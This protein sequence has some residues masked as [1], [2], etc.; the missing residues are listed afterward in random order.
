MP[1]QNEPPSS[2]SS[3]FLEKLRRF[4]QGHERLKHRVHNGMRVPLP[5]WGRV[6]MGTIYF[7]VPV[8]T[9]WYLLQWTTKKSQESME[10]RLLPFKKVQ[11]LGDKR[12][13]SDGQMIKI[14][15]GGWGGGVHLA[16]SDEA[17]QKLNNEM[18][19]KLV[20]QQRRK[21]KRYLKESR[22]KNAPREEPNPM[23]S[24]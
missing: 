11:G 14:G 2:Q 23:E 9:G 18:W 21:R 24:P 13:D 17:T 16:V 12:L 3:W 7:S 10:E 5:F 6:I 1:P 4:H 15:A 19:N 8:A 20:K 22:R